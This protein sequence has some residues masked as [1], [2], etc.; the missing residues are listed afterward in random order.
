MIRITIQDGATLNDAVPIFTAAGDPATPS[1]SIA[2]PAVVTLDHYTDP[3]SGHV[4][5]RGEY[6]LLAGSP[7]LHR[8]TEAIPEY[9]GAWWVV[10]PL[11]FVLAMQSLFRALGTFK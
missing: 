6:I 2:G 1:A 3:I 10:M 5:S 9:M 4:Y 11:V 7:T 8:T